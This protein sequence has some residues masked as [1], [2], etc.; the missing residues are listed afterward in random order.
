METRE[1]RWNEGGRERGKLDGNAKRE[2]DCQRALFSDR[3]KTGEN[4][5]LSSSRGRQTF[6]LETSFSFRSPFPPIHCHRRIID[7]R[8]SILTLNVMKRATSRPMFHDW[9]EGR[10]F[11]DDGKV[12]AKGEGVVKGM[13]WRKWPFTFRN[14]LSLPCRVK[15]WEFDACAMPTI[16]FE[17]LKPS[18][19]SKSGVYKCVALC[20]RLL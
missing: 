3:I 13:A 16:L 11:F 10:A 15:S 18:A 7:I 14:F 1:K 2:L 8:Y 5:K 12:A 6:S 9:N 4:R 19:P 17:G 20:Y